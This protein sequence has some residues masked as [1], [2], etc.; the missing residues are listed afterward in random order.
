MSWI[1]ARCN[2][3]GDGEDGLQIMYGIRGEKKLTEI[4][5]DHLEGYKKSS[6]VRIG[7]GAYD[8]LQLD[9]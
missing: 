8:Q 2:D 4:E 9:M 3:L 7:N 5:L 6:P 1:E